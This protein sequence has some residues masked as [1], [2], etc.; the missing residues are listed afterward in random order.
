MEITVAQ[1]TVNKKEPTISVSGIDNTK[2]GSHYDLI[3]ID[4]AVSQKNTTN[5][6]QMDQ[7]LNWYRL[8]LSMLEPDGRL[9]ISGTRYDFS[10]LYS[11]MLSQP[12]EYDVLMEK[13]VRDDGSLFWPQRLTR[14]FLDQ[15]LRLQGTYVFNT[16]YMLTPV[17]GENQTFHDK[18]VVYYDDFIEQVDVDS[19]D[20]F[21]AVDPSLT[22]KEEDK[23]DS[24]AMVVVGL[25]EINNW[26]ILDIVNQKLTPD[27][28]NSTLLDL[29]IKWKPI[30][31]G[32]E[33]VVFSRLLKFSFEKYC[34]ERGV[35]IPPIEELK[36]SGKSKELRI[37]SLQPLF[38]N[39]KVYMK[40]PDFI[41]HD[42]WYNMYEQLIHFPKAQHD[43]LIDALA[44]I[45]SLVYYRTPLT[46][47]QPTNPF[48][49]DKDSPWF[50][51]NLT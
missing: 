32:I 24:T 20:K 46:Q 3:I 45:H 44:Y 12:D 4:D 50:E 8:L 28:I 18:D 39:H 51:G 15:Q 16:Q 41:E 43:D 27:K 21:I 29:A 42:V 6:E 47:E 38:E 31:V 11:S 48:E 25:D 7:V 17:S 14:E 9:V 22:G 35:E 1:R 34:M 37:K 36:T 23:G 19:L 49:K 5:R 2:T 13:A 26:Y 33:S 40:R 10:D 30:K